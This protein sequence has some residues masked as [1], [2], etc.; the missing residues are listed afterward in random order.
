MRKSW[1]KGKTSEN[2]PR[3]RK[4]TPEELEKMRQ[5]QKRRVER[6]KENNQTWHRTGVLHTEHTKEQMRKARSNQIFPK[7]DTKIEKMMQI[8]LSL[9]GIKWTKQKLFENDQFYHRVDLFIEPNICVECDG[10]YWHK[11]PDVVNR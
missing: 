6:L 8:A 10:D 3:I 2:D 5:G 4:H 9:N 11:K 7:K 1:S